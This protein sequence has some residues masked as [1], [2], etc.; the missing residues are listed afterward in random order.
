MTASS[1]WTGVG[2]LGG[3]LLL[4]LSISGCD[5][6]DF[7][8]TESVVVE[9]FVEAERPLPPVFVRAVQ[10]L[11]DTTASGIETAQVRLMVDDPSQGEQSVAYAPVPGAPGRYEPVNASDS[12]GIGMRFRLMVEHANGTAQGRSR[13]PAPIRLDSIV[14]SV[15]NKP[16]EAVRVD[17]LRR[18]SLDIPTTTNFIYP[19]DVEAYWT[20]PE[21]DTAWVR[22]ALRPENQPFTPRLVD[23]FIQPEAVF[24]ESTAGDTDLRRWRGVYAIPVQEATDPLPIHRLVV[25]IARGDAEYASFMAE[26]DDPDRREPPSNVTG[27]LG[28]ITGVAMDSVEVEVP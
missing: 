6:T 5:L 12:I 7:E 11:G 18:D 17:S 22:T 10:G 24:Q 21:A 23:F 26:R 8:A 28:I 3:V 19:I 25:W 9:A 15:P 1:F 27:G 20:A 16:V 13:T 2:V 4:V 14:T